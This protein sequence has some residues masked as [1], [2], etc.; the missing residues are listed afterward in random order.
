MAI[1]SKSGDLSPERLARRVRAALGSE[2]AELVLKG[3]SVLDVFQ[4]SWKV[5]DVAV[6]DGVIVGVGEA[7]SGALEIDCAGKW[8]VPGFID[9]HVHI[10]SSLMVPLRFQEAVLPRGTTTALWDPHEIAN[11]L[12]KDGVSWACSEAEQLLLDVF[13]LLPSCVPATGFETPGASLSAADLVPFAQHP[14]VLGL[15][16]FMNVPGVLNG[17]SGCVEKL[18]AFRGA[19]RDGHAPSVH[20]KALSAYLCAGITA[21]HESTTL[22]EAGE[23]LRKGMHVLIREGSCAKDADALLPLVTPLSSAVVAFCSDDRNPADVAEEGHVDAILRKGLARGMDPVLLFRCASFAAARAYGLGDRGVIGPGFIADLCVLEAAPGKEAL[24]ADFGFHSVWKDGRRVEEAA[25][26]Q[27]ADAAAQTRLPKM[28]R[29]RNIQLGRELRPVDFLF[30]DGAPQSRVE[31][32]LISVTEGSLLSDSLRAEIPTCARGFLRADPTKDLLHLSVCERHHGSGNIGRAFVRGFKLERGAMASSIG[33]DS[34][35]IT[36]VGASAEAM[37]AAV[38]H[39]ARIDGGICVVDEKGTVLADLA[40][41]VGGLMTWV[42]LAEVE[43]RLRALKAA[44]QA[45]GCPLAEPFLQMSFLALPVIPSLKLT[46]KGLVD[47]ERFG[48]TSLLAS[49]S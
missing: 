37:A 33:H 24:D 21:C 27:A 8:V 40:L 26:A 25:L 19:V 46:D 48:F 2:P 49:E 42:P 3:A 5:G 41:P 29:P 38:A 44:A 13:V 7:Y 36:V 15:A 34:H 9:S 17:D 1:R 11:V 28:V 16:E 31:I 20:G 30:M 14:Q 4:G 47:V 32:K 43:A 12:G 23:K 39:L 18:V 22:A 6:S 35:N 10:E 45:L